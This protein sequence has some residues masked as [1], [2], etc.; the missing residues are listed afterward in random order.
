MILTA[1]NN[2]IGLLLM[3]A[4]L[5]DYFLFKLKN[6][7][8]CFLQ[9]HIA[10]RCRKLIHR[11]SHSSC[12]YNDSNNGVKDVGSLSNAED[13]LL[14]LF[15]LQ[16]KIFVSWE[17]TSLEAKISQKVELLTFLPL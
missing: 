3:N 5:P 15:P 9:E 8:R 12:R 16:V 4:L 17:T 11:L 2:I 14:E 1:M 10:Y 7:S 13:F 6:I